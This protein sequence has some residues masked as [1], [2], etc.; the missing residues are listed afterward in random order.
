MLPRKN[1]IST[2]Q[3]PSVLRGK[4]TQ[5]EFFRVVIKENKDLL[6]PKCAVVVPNKV[7]K[8]AVSRNR[9]RRQVYSLLDGIINKL[10]TAYISIFPKKAEMTNKEL[11][12]L[13]ELLLK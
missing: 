11:I 12:C 4:I 1:R 3:F 2:E 9:A 7:A 8:T 5:N 13:K 6:V 10:P